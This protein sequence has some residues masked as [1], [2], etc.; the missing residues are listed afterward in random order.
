MAGRLAIAEGLADEAR[1]RIRR[2]RAER[3]L[4]ADLWADLLAA[5]VDPRPETMRAALAKSEAADNLHAS[6]VLRYL[7]GE[8]GG[9]GELAAQGVRNPDRLCRLVVPRIASRP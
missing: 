2:L 3:V 5:G 6:A 1:R 9:A 4:Y 8:A 7:L